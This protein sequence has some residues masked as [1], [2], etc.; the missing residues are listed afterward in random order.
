M[1]YEYVD[2]HIHLHGFEEKEREILLKNREFIFLAVANDV[3][4]SFFN[5]KLSLLYENVIPAVGIHP[6]NIEKTKN[7]DMA[8]I[9]NI[10]KRTN[11]KVLGEIGIDK[12]FVPGTINKQREFFERFLKLAKEYDLSVNLHTPDAW[13]EV[14]DI[15]IKYDIKKAYFH[16]YTGP[17]SMLEEIQSNQYFVGINPAIFLQKKHQEV[18]RYAD[19]DNIITESD[20]PYKYKGIYLHPEKIEEV[21]N[22]I[23]ERK[24]VD[25][26]YLKI[27][28]KEN[29]SRFLS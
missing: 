27:R 3:S 25:S 19:L 17:V 7:E 15:L 23:A 9:E 1:M 6:W 24:K 26:K 28:L 20:A 2:A 11:I 13:E 10:I 5:M 21:I 16:W 22:Y 12:K 18:L 29:L 4:S 8:K 14:F